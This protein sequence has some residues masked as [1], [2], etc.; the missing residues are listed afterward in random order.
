MKNVNIIQNKFHHLAQF[1]AAF[2]NSFLPTEKDDSQSNMSWSIAESALISRIVNGIFLKLSYADLS[3]TVHY[4]QIAETLD[5]T[6][7][8]ISDIDSWIR[9][10]LT[11]FGLHAS[12]FNYKLGFDLPTGFDTFLSVNAE[13]EKIIY[14]LIEERNIAQKALESIKE[15]YSDTSEIRIWPHHFDTG[16]LLFEESYGMG[17]GY[18][19]ADKHCDV[20]YYYVSIWGKKGINIQNSKT[21]EHVEWIQGDWNGLI[22]PISKNFDLQRIIMFYDDAIKIFREI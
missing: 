8:G 16:M 6:G 17:L 14:Q 4:R 15:N 3:L 11:E 7:L 18:A 13:D 20:P 5:L 21:M 19:I 9:E 22:Y 1:L 12:D 2:S 10:A